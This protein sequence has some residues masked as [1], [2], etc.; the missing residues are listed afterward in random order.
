MNA[1]TKTRPQQI[2]EDI[3]AAVDQD[4]G[5]K[6]VATEPQAPQAPK[7]DPVPTGKVLTG[8]DLL[9]A[10]IPS[11]RVQQS[12]TV[13]GEISVILTEI[14]NLEYGEKRNADANRVSK[15]SGEVALKFYSALSSGLVSSEGMRQ[16]LGDHFGWRRKGKATERAEKEAERSSTPFGQGEI[17]RQRVNRGLKAKAY[18]NGGEPD[19]FFKVLERET[20]QEYIAEIESGEG[21]LF[22]MYDDLRDERSEALKTGDNAPVNPLFNP[23]KVAKMVHTLTE[24]GAG[25]FFVNN[26][27]LVIAWAAVVEAVSNIQSNLMARPDA[28]TILDAVQKADASKLELAA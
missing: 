13:S 3:Q 26:P 14:A 11:N 5:D 7:A 25:D 2:V 9:A 1:Q 15:L 16:M 4:T 19:N 6:G 24:P 27:L 28:E 17:I 23:Q 12:D 22:T 10:A 20:V 21:S 8:A 18:A